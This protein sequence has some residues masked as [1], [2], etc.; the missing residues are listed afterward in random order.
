MSFTLYTLGYQGLSL[1]AY[2]DI[3][4]EHPVRKVLDVRAAAWSRKPGFIKSTMQEGLGEAGIDYRHLRSAGNPFRKDE[5]SDNILEKYREYLIKHPDPLEAI[6]AEIAQSA[7]E[8]ASVC[9]TC[10]EK[11][12]QDCHRSIISELLLQRDPR[13]HVI[14]LGAK[15]DQLAL[16]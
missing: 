11:D 1:D 10:F 16:L 13:L 7:K 9:L 4:K 12:P 15:S 8:H 6:E 5:D 2:I 14:H 3:L